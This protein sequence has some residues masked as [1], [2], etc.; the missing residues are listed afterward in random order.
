MS[1]STWV[2]L[3][4]NQTADG[5]SDGFEHYGSTQG[6]YV[7]GV[8]GTATL[9]LEAKLPPEAQ[10]PNAPDTYV[11]V[12]NGQWR[13][14]DMYDTPYQVGGV[15]AVGMMKTLNSVPAVY[16]MRLIGAD[17]TTAVWAYMTRS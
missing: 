4:D 9:I 16:R 8:L 5:E 13:Q 3:F 2:Q 14:N 1:R 17:V 15:D 10:N 7:V 12:V 11:P 6:I